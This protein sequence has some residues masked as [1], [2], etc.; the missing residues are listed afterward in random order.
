MHFLTRL[1]LVAVTALISLGAIAALLPPHVVAAVAHTLESEDVNLDGSEEAQF[2]RYDV[3]GKLESFQCPSMTTFTFYL[4][5]SSTGGITVGLC[6]KGALLNENMGHQQEQG[7]EAAVTAVGG[8]IDYLRKSLGDSIRLQVIR[9]NGYVFV[10]LAQWLMSGVGGVGGHGAGLIETLLMIP[11]NGRTVVLVQGAL[12]QHGCPTATSQSTLPKL[13]LCADFR[14]VMREVSRQAY[15][16]QKNPPPPPAFTLEPLRPGQPTICDSIAWAVGEALEQSDTKKLPVTE[17]VRYKQY[18]DQP[19]V[20]SGMR[21]AADDHAKGVSISTT[22]TSVG[23]RCY[24]KY[25]SKQ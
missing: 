10:H 2:V 15:A 18:G 5:H 24:A 23:K 21:Q 9:E 6:P 11:P 1:G 20:Q 25:F 8:N 14:G 22:A 4:F 3:A 12:P 17:T 7:F 16:A 13:P 19:E